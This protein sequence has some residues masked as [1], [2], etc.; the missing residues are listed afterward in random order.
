[1]DEKQSA[2]GW[3]LFLDIDQWIKQLLDQF[4]HAIPQL[5]LFNANLNKTTATNMTDWIDHFVVTIENEKI[6]QNFGFIKREGNVYRR[7]DT[8]FPSFR[9]GASMEVALKV[10]SIDHFAG[11][12]GVKYV[13]GIKNGAYRYALVEEKNCYRWSVIERRGCSHYETSMDQ[14]EVDIYLSFLKTF[15]ERRRDYENIETGFFHLREM[16]L[17][18]VKKI[19]LSRVTDAFFKA[20]RDYWESRNDVAQWQKKRQD[21]FG[22][23]W[24]N[25]DHHTYR[26]SRKYFLP[27]IHLFKL[28]GFEL[29]ERFY[30]GKESGWGAQV[31]EHHDCDIVIFADVDLGEYEK[32]VDFSSKVLSERTDLGTIGLW[33]GLHGESMFSA[34]LHHLE[35]RFDFDKLCSDLKDSG[36]LFMSPFSDYDFLKQSFSQGQLWKVDK[37]RLVRLLSKDSINPLEYDRF[38]KEGAIGSHL[39]NLERKWGYKGFN[40]KSVSDIL[41]R[42]NPRRK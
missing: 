3:P 41:E 31:L 29:R 6:L 18:M 8:V 25:H 36:G 28:F 40:Q 35:A 23:G 27:L 37:E 32:D 39:E 22:L 2:F 15:K 16:I 33:C 11:V 34:G 5:K 26:S 19:D 10:D 9:I 13:K 7:D 1:M 21:S 17:S 42:V 30:A 12:H 38:L 24:S 14:D 20:E 4:Y